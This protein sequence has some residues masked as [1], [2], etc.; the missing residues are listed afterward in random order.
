[1]GA[2]EGS[3]GLMGVTPLPK[4]GDTICRGSPT[5]WLSST[6]KQGQSPGKELGQSLQVTWGSTD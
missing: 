4:G 3:A 5:P 6:K 2:E 1:M